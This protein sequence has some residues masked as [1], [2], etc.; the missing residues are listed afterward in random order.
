MLTNREFVNFQK[1]DFFIFLCTLTINCV[2]TGPRK[3]PIKYM[4]CFIWNEQCIEIISLR[5]TCGLFSSV[6]TK[7]IPY[8][9]TPT[10]QEVGGVT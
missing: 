10:L 8:N 1:R 6:F 4:L 7:I 2:T 5:K 9:T 3:I